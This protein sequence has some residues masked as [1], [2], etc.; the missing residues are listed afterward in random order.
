MD[1]AL[2]DAQ[3]AFR[4]EVRT[5]LDKS[6]SAELRRGAAPTS[7][8]FAEPDIARAWQAILEA[9]GWLVYHWPE[10]AGGP[11]WTP[12]QRWIFEKECAEAGAPI[13][14]GM[15]LKLV[16]PVLYTYGSEA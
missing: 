15:G 14:P 3:R 9:K 1:L 2:T 4:D 13:L 6:L 10:A 5:F 12:T 11:G 16:G 7:G 8:V